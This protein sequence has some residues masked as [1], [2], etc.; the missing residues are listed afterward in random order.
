M[1]GEEKHMIAL[2]ATEKQNIWNIDSGC[3]KHMTRHPNKFISLRK[4]NKGKFTFGDNMSSKIIGKGTPV[5][6]DKIKYKNVFLVEYLKP[7]I[8]SVSQT[9]DQGNIC[10]FYSKKCEIGKRDS[11]RLVGTAVRNSSNVYILENEEHCYMSMIDE[12]WLWHRRLQHLNF[13]NI[14]KVSKKEDVRDSPKIVKP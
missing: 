14:V 8:L 12:I 10:I 5:V 3:S 6:N 13:D 7:N 4:G 11:G 9:C 1:K 2:C